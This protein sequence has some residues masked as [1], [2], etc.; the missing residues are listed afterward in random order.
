[1]NYQQRV[2]I[3]EEALAQV[4]SL[5]M[6]KGKDYGSDTDANA[7]FKNTAAKLG[8]TP[9]QV[10]AIYVDKHQSAIANAI[11]RTPENPQ[12]LAESIEESILDVITYHVI[13]LTLLEDVRGQS[14]E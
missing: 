3:A 8:V 6:S 10:W 9:F 5:L 14:I 12:R 11:Q 1:M 4:K 13:L 2:Q 7:N